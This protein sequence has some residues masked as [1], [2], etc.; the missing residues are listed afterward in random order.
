MTASLQYRRLV[1]RQEEIGG[2][3]LQD[4]LSTAQEQ[5]APLDDL[6]GIMD[7][8]DFQ[9]SDL[10]AG[11][12]TI[13]LVLP[14]MRMG[15]RTGGCASIIQQALVAIEEA[16]GPA[17]EKLPVWFVLEEFSSLGHL[18]AIATAAGLMA[19]FGVKLWPVLQDLTQL[20]TNYARA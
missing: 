17:G 15:T 14:G 11:R 16:P 2:R 19:G 7:R 4:I 8:S 18:R 20:K 12:T 9:L 3:E 13:Y 10:S 6:V 1:S 5:T